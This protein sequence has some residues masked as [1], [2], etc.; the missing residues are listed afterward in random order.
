MLLALALASPIFLA[1]QQGWDTRPKPRTFSSPAGAWSLTITSVDG[2]W[3]GVAEFVMQ[4]E[5]ASEVFLASTTRDVQP[6]R[7][8]D[9]REFPAPG[10]VTARCAQVWAAKEREDLD[11]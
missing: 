9:D 8:W 5:G 4:R 7:R 3:N 6:V 2:N 10:P 11:P 1:S